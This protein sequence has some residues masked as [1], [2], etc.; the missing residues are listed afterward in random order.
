MRD[1]Q[2]AISGTRYQI[3]SW[4]AEGA[5]ALMERLRPSAVHHGCCT[6]ADEVLGL[7]ACEFGSAPTIVGHPAKGVP[8]WFRSTKV[9]CDFLQ[10]ELPPLERNKVMVAACHV[11]IA[12]PS[13]SDPNAR[14]GTWA[15]IR[16]AKKL[17]GRS[18]HLIAVFPPE[19]GARMWRVGTLPPELRAP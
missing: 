10:P 17:L 5:I 19:H 15:T 18:M 9:P 12:C 1:L 6:G 2:L 11:L 4:Q 7:A 14:S 3:P 16:A 13:T 8:F